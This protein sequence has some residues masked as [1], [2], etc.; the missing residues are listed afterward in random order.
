MHGDVALPAFFPDGTRAVIRSLDAQDVRLTGTPGIVMNAY[1]LMRHPGINVLS[2][3]GG[4]HAFTG[5]NGPILTDSGGFQVYSLLRENPSL[6]VVRRNEAVF[7][8]DGDKDKV[9]LSPEKSVRM[10]VSAR[11]DIIMC[12][13][14]CIHPDDPPGVNARSVETTVR[15]ARKCRQEF[16]RLVE[17]RY[18]AGTGAGDGSRRPLLFGIIQGGEDE[19]LRRECAAALIDMKFDGYSFGGW[20]LD[21]ERNLVRDTLE[22]TASLM[23]DDLPRYAMGI[24]KPENVVACVRMGYNLF[25]SVIPTRD[26]RHLR[27]YVFNAPRLEDVRPDGDFYSTLYMQDRKH[28]RDD[29]P[30]S[31]ACDCYTC[32]NYSRAY[33]YHL[34]RV[35]DGLADRL[36]TIHNLRFYAELMDLLKKEVA[37]GGSRPQRR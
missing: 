26:A 30:I 32:R 15:W 23:P 37:A 22:L 3:L 16:D 19:V 20:P 9:V 18:D 27:L 31:E 33:L 12:L 25:D 1:H 6:G 28:M 7:T 35:E 5:W 14:W 13:D 29:G 21:G 24:G 2:H 34:F 17:E 4:L 8:A 36:A 11:S 10:Q